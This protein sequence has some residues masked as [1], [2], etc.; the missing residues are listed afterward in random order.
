LVVSGTGFD[1]GATTYADPPGAQFDMRTTQAWTTTHH[2]TLWELLTTPDNSASPSNNLTFNQNGQLVITPTS[3]IVEDRHGVTQ[4]VYPFAR[5]DTTE[6]YV[7]SWT[8]NDGGSST[9]KLLVS[10]TGNATAASR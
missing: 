4:T 5:T 3:G 8:S 6:R 9:W 7:A 1:G 2:G 10:A